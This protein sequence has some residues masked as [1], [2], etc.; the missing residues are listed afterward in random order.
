MIGYH[1]VLQ[2]L[3]E[4]LYSG[5]WTHPPL[6]TPCPDW[7]HLAEQHDNFFNFFFS[8]HYVASRSRT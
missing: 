3:Q 5:E 6:R 2:L 8:W 1:S 4:K 7:L